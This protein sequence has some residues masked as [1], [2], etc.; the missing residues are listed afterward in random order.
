[1]GDTDERERSPGAGFTQ[2]PSQQQRLNK[3]DYG[4]AVWHPLKAHRTDEGNT[5]KMDNT[6]ISNSLKA[7]GKGVMHPALTE[8]SL[9]HS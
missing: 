8:V 3:T 2:C 1:M 5:N 9:R 7:Q 4:I 6:M